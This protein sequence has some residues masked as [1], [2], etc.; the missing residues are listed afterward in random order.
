MPQLNRFGIITNMY[1]ALHEILKIKG[2]DGL[3]FSFLFFFSSGVLLKF[4]VN[5]FYG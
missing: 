3:L 1:I 5:Y 2:I 4:Y